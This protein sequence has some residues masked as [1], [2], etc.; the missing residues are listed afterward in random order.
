MIVGAIRLYV[1]STSDNDLL[2]AMD[3]FR[4]SKSNIREPL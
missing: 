4:F 2:T 3:L 1:L